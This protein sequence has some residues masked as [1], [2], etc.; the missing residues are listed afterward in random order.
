MMTKGN[1]RGAQEDVVTLFMLDNY[2]DAPI[3]RK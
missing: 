2:S 1:G 3:E